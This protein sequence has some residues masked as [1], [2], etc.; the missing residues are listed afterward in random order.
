MRAIG[1]FSAFE[2]PFAQRGIHRAGVGAA[3]GLHLTERRRKRS[4]R[5]NEK[6]RSALAHVLEDRRNPRQGPGIGAELLRQTSD[7]CAESYPP[8]RFRDCSRLRIGA[9]GRAVR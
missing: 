1:S 3:R 4:C 2:R 5:R 8:L 7:Q 9:A 6:I